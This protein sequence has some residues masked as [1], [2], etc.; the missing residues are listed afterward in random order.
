MPTSTPTIIP[1][2]PPSLLLI[3][4]S[5]GYQSPT[6]DGVFSDGEWT[7]PQLHIEDPIPTNIYFRNDDAFLYVC[8]D[9]DGDETKDGDDY[10]DL[11]F[12]TINQ[13]A[14][15]SGHEDHFRIWGDG[16]NEHMIA[17]NTSG[18]WADCCDFD[19]HPGLEGASGFGS[20]PN[21]G[22]KHRI[23]EFKIPL[24]LLEAAPG[25]TIGFSSGHDSIPFDADT[26]RHNVWPLGY[27]SSDMSTMGVLVLASPSPA[28]VSAMS[29]WGMI[30]TAI[31]IGMAI[32][33]AGIL[34]WSVRRRR[35]I[36]GNKKPVEAYRMSL[37]DQ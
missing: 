11:I 24:S 33:F 35:I 8:V 4:S 30:G 3:E 21:S 32:L 6:I 22:D 29:H 16:S 10:S 5:W 34:I 14:W 9:T 1:T 27:D 19:L 13:G 26:G 20:S 31:M 12:D 2:L 25:D 37:N 18:V 23:Y 28:A 7:N 15:D 36:Y 17:S